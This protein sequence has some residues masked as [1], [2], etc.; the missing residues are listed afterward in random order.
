MDNLEITGEE[1]I[2]EEATERARE[3]GER[4]QE[5]LEIYNCSLDATLTIGRQGVKPNV[6]V[7]A[8]KKE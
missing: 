8:K 1:N 5:I 3:C 7:V 6:F 4:I 2:T